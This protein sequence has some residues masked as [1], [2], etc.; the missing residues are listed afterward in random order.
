MDL[1]KSVEN[2]FYL[3]GLH[4]FAGTLNEIVLTFNKP[5]DPA[6]ATNL[7]T[8]AIPTSRLTGLPLTGASIGVLP[9]WCPPQEQDRRGA[10][11]LP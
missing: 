11:I 9:S 10:S 3:V 8:Y 5:V 7:T 2:Q 6:T 4:G 1:S